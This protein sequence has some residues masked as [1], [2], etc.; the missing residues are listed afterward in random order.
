M[1]LLFVINFNRNVFFLKFDVNVCK[2]EKIKM[3][4]SVYLCKM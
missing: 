2:T 4:A 3:V 1:N